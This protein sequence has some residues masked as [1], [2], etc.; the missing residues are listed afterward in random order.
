MIA[1]KAEVVT[2]L[3]KGSS[4][5]AA[6]EAL[7]D[8]IHPLAERALL[9]WVGQEY[10]YQQHVEYLPIQDN[11]SDRD[12]AELALDQVEKIGNSVIITGRSVGADAIILRNTPVWQTG[13]EVREDAGA[14]A[15]QS[16]DAF[17]S[18]TVLTLGEDY[19]LDL[20]GTTPSTLSDTG[21]L[22]RYGVWPTEPR[23]IKVTY[24]GG[25]SAVQ[26]QNGIGG[27]VK[28]AALLTVA[29]A[30][31]TAKMWQK[32]GRFGPVTGESLGKYSWQGGTQIAA[33]MTAGFTVPS[34]A[35]QLLWKRRNFANIFG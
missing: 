33:A 5:A 31:K 4:L 23:S 7:L 17:G 32:D 35:Q 13:L 2:Y 18:E 22:H 3:G 20:N 8:L 34:E 26:L 11:Y 24:Y 12:G 14:F 19:W 30:W 6:D 27:S 29:K 16:S 9:D 15:G 10:E 21:I 28:L 25:Y 1:S